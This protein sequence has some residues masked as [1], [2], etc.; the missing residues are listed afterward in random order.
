[1]TTVAVIGTALGIRWVAQGPRRAEVVHTETRAGWTGRITRI[2]PW[3]EKTSTWVGRS[4]FEIELMDTDR[5]IHR[6]MTNR[7]LDDAIDLMRHELAKRIGPK[8]A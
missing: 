5:T 4:K 2:G 7:E 3:S 1:M 6:L 8:V